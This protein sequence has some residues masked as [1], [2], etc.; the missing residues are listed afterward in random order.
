MN[1]SALAND[2]GLSL[3][4]QTP[5]GDT[6]QH[7]GLQGLVSE[8]DISAGAGFGTNGGVADSEITAGSFLLSDVS[9]S[10]YPTVGFGN[11]VVRASY[12]KYSNGNLSSGGA[13]YNIY[14]GQ[15]LVAN[16]S[17]SAGTQSNILFAYCTNQTG[18]VVNNL[19]C[20]GMKYVTSPNRYNNGQ[21]ALYATGSITG[22]TN[23]GC[24]SGCD[25]FLRNDVAGFHSLFGGGLM[26]G[27]NPAIQT[28]ASTLNVI[29]SFSMT[30]SITNAQ[31]AT[32]SANP[33]CTAGATTYQ[34]ALVARDSNGAATAALTLNQNSCANNVTAGQPL[35]VTSIVSAGASSFDIYLTNAGGGTCNGGACVLGKVGTVTPSFGGG[36]LF[37]APSFAYTGTAGDGTT[38]PN[39]NTTGGIKTAPG[40]ISHLTGNTAYLDANFTTANNTNLQAIT[41]TSH[42]LAF[43]LPPFAQV[44]S[45]HCALS[46]SQGT[47]NAAVAF[48]IQAATVAPNNIFVN[49]SQQI[50]VGPPATEVNGTLPTLTTTTATAIVTGTPGATATNYVVTLD[51]TIDEPA[52]AN[53][54]LINFMVST[55]TGTDPVTVPKGGYCQL[56]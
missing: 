9:T 2:R 14:Q 21:T 40:S 45:F 52:N 38:P 29:G 37:P 50:T 42:N 34:M 48:G 3:F 35:N 27:G 13:Q 55:A 11:S 15:L 23:N 41:G 4:Y 12:N 49:A 32:V 5:T 17:F 51:G 30:G 28:A 18:G 16:S 20:N 56:F 43:T 19:Q 1:T 53:G 10:N 7:Y 31:L 25:L 46:Y 24:V 47:A 26:I 36:Q 22:I 6:T 8:I 39:V 33:G 54:N 44:Y